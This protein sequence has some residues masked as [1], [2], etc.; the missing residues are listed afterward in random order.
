MRTVLLV[1]ATLSLHLGTARTQAGP[2]RPAVDEE[3]ACERAART[4]AQADEYLAESVFDQAIAGYV[5]AFDECKL[6]KV[7]AAMV[8][9]LGLAYKRRA[10]AATV[11]AIAAAAEAAD[12]ESADRAL[13]A[14]G[15]ANEDRKK[16]L[17]RFRDFLVWAPE[18][19]LSDEARSYVFRLQ[20]DLDDEEAAIAA[21]A[22]RLEDARDQRRRQAEVAR[23]AHAGRKRLQLASVVVAGVG[24]GLVGGGTYCGWRAHSL[25]RELSNVDD[26]TTGTMADVA[27]GER[28]ER[29]M[30]GL[31][32]G[33]GVVLAT[34]GTLFWYARRGRGEESPPVMAVI[35]D[36]G[37]AVAGRF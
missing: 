29:R 19:R 8:F 33:G 37:V 26:W 17:G 23:R 11:A 30:L 22:A 32:I 21:E 20:S 6:E 5:S 4:A 10:E 14:R 7:R 2:D 24:V 13:A 34:A 3:A 28:A 31:T 25:S 18:G 35:S 15:A 12:E 9:N 27:A 1:L 36:S 16:A